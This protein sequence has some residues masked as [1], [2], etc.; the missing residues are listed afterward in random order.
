M[1]TSLMFPSQT[2][3]C[4]LNSRTEASIERTIFRP[5]NYEQILEILS[6]RLADLRLDAL[7]DKLR[8]MIARKAASVAGDLRAALK[9]C[10]RTIELYRD[11]VNERRRQKR[12]AGRVAAAGSTGSTSTGDSS[13]PGAISLKEFMVLAKEAAN[14]YTQTPFI[15]ATA[16]AC[17]LDKAIL[18]V[19]GR[20]RQSVSGGEGTINEAAMTC[21]A[22]WERL[23]DITQKIDAERYLART[24]AA[25]SSS[26]N[27]GAAGQPSPPANSVSQLRQPP[28]PIFVQALDRLCSQGILVQANTWK[29]VLGPRS[30]LYSLHP[31]FTFSDLSAALSG[32]PMLRYCSH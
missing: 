23:C 20:H 13:D 15:A 32:D 31:N 9:I 8:Q 28:F 5:Y 14:S 7:D 25:S 12:V 6:R 10:Q 3:E 4:R 19:L 30:V 22:V 11:A 17:Q 27:G 24:S 21:D 16:R 1:L 18:A 29:V 2:T 26:T